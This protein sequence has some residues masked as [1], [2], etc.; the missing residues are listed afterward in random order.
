MKCRHHTSVTAGT[1]FHST[2]LPLVKWF[3][4]ICLVASD[5]GGISAM[6]LSKQIDISWIT[7]RSMLKK[8]R[9]AMA[10]RDSIYRLFSERVELD[11][12]FVGGKKPGKR[13]RGAGGKKPVLVAVEKRGKTAGFVSMRAVEIISGEEIKR[14]LSRSVLQGQQPGHP[15]VYDPPRGRPHLAAPGPYRDQ[16]HEDLYQW[17]FPW[18]N[19]QIS[20][21]ISG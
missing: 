19:P 14:F 7:A 21:G 17:H 2:N 13:G 20:P 9:A 4:A 12:A 10:H 3:W 6:R 16:K 8:I 11:D 5:K 18:R 1:L 15:G